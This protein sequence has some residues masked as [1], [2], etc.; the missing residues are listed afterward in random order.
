[1]IKKQEIKFCQLQEQLFK[2][3]QDDE[4]LA[5]H[6][7]TPILKNQ[8]PTNS[9]YKCPKI[10]W[11][12]NFDRKS[13]TKSTRPPFQVNQ[14]KYEFLESNPKDCEDEPSNRFQFKYEVLEL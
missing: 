7:N 8:S 14:K 11:N 3:V 9:A 2:L 1:M 12:Q 5:S 13:V 4:S 10:Q 6:S